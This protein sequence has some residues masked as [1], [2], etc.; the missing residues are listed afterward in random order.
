ML[1]GSFPCTEPSSGYLA[2][3]AARL[4]STA[5]DR[6]WS[7]QTQ[8][9][10]GQLGSSRLVFGQ[11]KPTQV[12]AGHLKLSE[13]DSGLTQ[14]DSGRLR[15]AQV[16]LGVKSNSGLSGRIGSFWVV[17]HRFGSTR[18]DS[19]SDRLGLTRVDSAR[20]GSTQVVSGRLRST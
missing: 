2:K 8:V 3:G 13:V 12:D 4:K 19:D 20:P 17:S 18:I 6:L 9:D 11:L 5:G 15:F 14:A 7:T 1:C 16:D 10:S